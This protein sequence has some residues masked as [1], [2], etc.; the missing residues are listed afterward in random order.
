MNLASLL[1]WECSLG[2]NWTGPMANLII[3]NWRD[4]PAQVIA[5]HGKGRKRETAK[6]ELNKRFALAIDSAAMKSSLSDSTDYLSFWRKSQPEYCSGNL[7]SE[8]ANL[9]VKIENDY[10]ALKL[11]ILVKNGGVED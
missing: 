7:H 6:V 9:A 10:D 11:A 4:I 8:A 3:V 5:E 2:I 1:P